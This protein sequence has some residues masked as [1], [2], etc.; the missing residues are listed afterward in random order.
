M[1]TV[2]ETALVS[3][4]ASIGTGTR[5]SLRAIMLHQFTP[6]TYHRFTPNMRQWF[7]PKLYQRFTPKLYHP[8]V[9]KLL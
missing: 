5:V 9:A 8:R 4:E 3:S 7:T 1:S 2:L 6:N